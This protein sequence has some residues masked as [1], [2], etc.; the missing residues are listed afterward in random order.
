MTLRVVLLTHVFPRGEDDAAAPFLLRYARGLAAAGVDLRVIA[1]HDPG[2]PEAHRVAGIAVRRVRYAAEAAEDLAYRGEMHVRARRPSGAWKAARLAVALGRATR[3]EAAAWRPDVLDVH[4][5]VPG[6]VVAWLARPPVPS[7]IVVHG[8]DLALVAGGGLRRRV[9]RRAAR[10]A[11]L[12]A[13]ASGPLADDCARVLG[14]PA[15][16]VVTMPPREPPARMPPPPGAGRVLAVGRLVAEKGHADLVEAA[17]RLRRH[18]YDVSLTVVG[19]GPERDRL[20]E[21]ARR[22]RVPLDLPGSV[23]PDALEDHYA[24]ADVVAV[25]SHREGFGLVAVEALDRGRPVVASRVGGLADVVTGETGW[26]VQPGDPLSL[27]SALAAVLDDPAEA[28][29]R[30]G[31]GREAVAGRWSPEAVGNTARDRLTRLARDGR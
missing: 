15:D 20:A 16:A 12:L 24:R 7:E 13:A 28:A 1:P 18:G 14:R 31:R 30:T 22:R 10:R 4:W 17:A 5:L 2:L 8:T 9:A 25:P 29:R 3:A 6:G 27:A 11:D 23:S 19:D 21:L 26:P